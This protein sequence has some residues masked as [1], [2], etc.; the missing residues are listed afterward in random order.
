MDIV[1]AYAISPSLLRL[2]ECGQQ[3]HYRKG[4]LIINEGDRSD[5]LFVILSGRVKAFSIDER[6][7]E[8]VYSVYG[9]GETVGEMSLD[10]GPRSANVVTLEPTECS[11]VTREALLD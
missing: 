1:T 8:I 9:V 2:A 3:R 6:D 10:G 7:R 11:V 4:A 5:T